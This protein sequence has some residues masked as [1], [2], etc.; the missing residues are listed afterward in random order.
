[1]KPGDL[2]TPNKWDIVAD[3]MIGYAWFRIA[4]AGNP[5]LR[6]HPEGAPQVH[7]HNI[8]FDPDDFP[9]SQKIEMKWSPG[10]LF[11][12][13]LANNNLALMVQMTSGPLGGETFTFLNSPALDDAFRT[14]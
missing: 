8:V 6:P 10:D 9:E 2:I 13:V 1:M 4:K 11:G 14:L 12:L 5:A 3:V 7:G